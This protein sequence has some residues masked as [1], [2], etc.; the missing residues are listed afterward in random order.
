MHRY[1]FK[2]KKGMEL[3]RGCAEQI[4]LEEV[5]EKSGRDMLKTHC[6]MCENLKK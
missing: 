4:G 5:G 1:I 3:R 6:I 2:I